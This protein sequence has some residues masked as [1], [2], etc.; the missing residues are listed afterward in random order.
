MLICH[1]YIFFGEVSG[2]VFCP[3][4][5]QTVF[6][7]LRVKSSLYILDNR[8]LPDVSFENIFS[9]PVICLLILLAMSFTEQK[10]LILI[11][12]SLP[13]IS[14]TDYAFGVASKNLSP[15]PRSSRFSP[16]LFSRSFIILDF[17]FMSVIH[18]ELIFV[19]GVRSVPVVHDLGEEE[20]DE[21]RIN[22]SNNVELLF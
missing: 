13:V 5:N 15:C 2:Q 21:A 8:H 19:K 7:L 4:L 17:T 6:L 1:L 14:S 12:S 10:F 20:E 16:M 11:K 22:D 18:F 3:F 9:Q